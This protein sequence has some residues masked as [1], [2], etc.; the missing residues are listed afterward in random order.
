[1]LLLLAPWHLLFVHS[2]SGRQVCR[3][4]ADN[5]CVGTIAFSWIV[6]PGKRLGGLAA[7]RASQAWRVSPRRLAQFRSGDVGL[8]LLGETPHRHE[9]LEFCP[10]IGAPGCDPLTSCG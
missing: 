7:K 3:P 1:M 6:Y 8:G 2:G 9:A 4:A 5:R 10:S